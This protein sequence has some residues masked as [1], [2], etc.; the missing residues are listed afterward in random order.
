[1]KSEGQ[2]QAPAE[3]E[4]HATNESLEKGVTT[5]EQSDEPAEGSA[6]RVLG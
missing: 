3:G 2:L 1:M 5:E 4:T 6:H